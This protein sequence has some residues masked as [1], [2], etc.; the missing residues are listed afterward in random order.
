M[1]TKPKLPM[2]VDNR[3]KQ[4]L[5]FAALKGFSEALARTEEAMEHCGDTEYAPDPDTEPA[6]EFID[7]SAESC[8]GE[9]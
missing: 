7:I 6:M 1:P 5:P 9:I 4:F 8:N 3:A 2:S